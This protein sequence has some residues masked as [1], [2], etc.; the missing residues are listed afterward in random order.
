MDFVPSVLVAHLAFGASTGTRP[1]NA[2]RREVLA[3]AGSPRYEVLA[4]DHAPEASSGRLSGYDCARVV[5]IYRFLPSRHSPRLLRLV[6]DL[7][8]LSADW[9]CATIISTT[10][11]CATIALAW[12]HSASVA[13][14]PRRHSQRVLAIRMTSGLVVHRL[15]A[16]RTPTWITPILWVR[17]RVATGLFLAAG[18]DGA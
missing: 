15:V 9:P 8:G 14:P 5:P 10:V 13:S 1:A 2:A 11:A 16:G 3:P 4:D 6:S 17:D 12:P 18:A 7:S